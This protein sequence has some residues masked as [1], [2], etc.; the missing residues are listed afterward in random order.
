MA[1]K[2]L[3]FLLN[4]AVGYLGFAFLWEDDSTNQRAGHDEPQVVTASA[5]GRPF[6]APS[7]LVS[8]AL[9]D[10]WRF[11][12]SFLSLK[13][14]AL[15]SDF[16]LFEITDILAQADG[17]SVREL[18]AQLADLPSPKKE[19]WLRGFY[20]A[21]MFRNPEQFWKEKVATNPSFYDGFGVLEMAASEVSRFDP[22]ML[23]GTLESIDQSYALKA[24]WSGSSQFGAIP[25]GRLVDFSLRFSRN[26][27]QEIFEDLKRVYQYEPD[28][29]QQLRVRLDK[30]EDVAERDDL[31]TRFDHFEREL[32]QSAPLATNLLEL[33]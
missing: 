20:R 1:R 28:G 4:A 15:E 7:D 23:V 16:T 17:K 12:P 26:E 33:K 6:V 5:V 21:Q 2:S 31:T 30:I 25:P 9:D 19:D 11:P 22:L 10:I 8:T 29:L 24:F 13:K 3:V 27:R 14:L 18:E 32:I